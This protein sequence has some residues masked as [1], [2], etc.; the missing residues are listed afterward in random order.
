[1]SAENSKQ[2]VVVTDIGMRFTSMIVFMIKWAIASIPALIIMLVVGAVFWSVVI[3]LFSSSWRTSAN[4]TATSG[5]VSALSTSSSLPHK[6]KSAALDATETAYLDKVAVKN[7]SV[8]QSV[9]G[10]KGVFGELKNTGN[11]TLKEVDITIYCLGA[12]GKAIFEE[13]YHPVLVSEFSS[14]DSGQP[15][16]PGY[17]RK[18]GVNMEDAPSEWHQR[19]DVKVTGVEFQ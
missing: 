15:L 19:V 18:F 8:G 12:G 7:V 11:R 14:G 5:G 10:E 17:I 16:K 9:L 1:M 4:Q 13:Q 6:D 3:A 2:E